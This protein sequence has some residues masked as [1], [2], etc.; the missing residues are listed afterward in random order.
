MSNNGHIRTF[1]AAA[2]LAPREDRHVSSPIRL[3]LQVSS[4]LR[5]HSPRRLWLLSATSRPF[6]R[7]WLQPGRHTPDRSPSCFTCLTD[8]HSHFFVDGRGFEPLWRFHGSFP[9]SRCAS[10]QYSHPYHPINILCSRTECCLYHYFP[11]GHPAAAGFMIHN[12][13]NTQ[14]YNAKRL[15]SPIPLHLSD[16]TFQSCLT[17]PQFLRQIP[18][19]P[20]MMCSVHLPYLPLLHLRPLVILHAQFHASPPSTFKFLISPLITIL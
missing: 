15:Q 17:H 9:L 1:C 12:E 2:V 11:M 14:V 5:Q 6:L 8:L 13:K 19:S 7:L 18:S 10:S 16:M 3:L 20:P 4:T